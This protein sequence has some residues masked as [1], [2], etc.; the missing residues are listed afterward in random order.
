MI[1]VCHVHFSIGRVDKEDVILQHYDQIII[2][3][4]LFNNY[5]LIVFSCQLTLDKIASL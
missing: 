4:V 5:N 1:V 2:F 3:S